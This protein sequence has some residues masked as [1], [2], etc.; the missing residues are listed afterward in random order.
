MSDCPSEGRE[1]VLPDVFHPVASPAAPGRSLVS[2]PVQGAPLDEANVALPASRANALR[3]A[4]IHPPRVPA[5]VREAEGPSSSGNGPVRKDL[6]PVSRVSVKTAPAGVGE[7]E[8]PPCEPSGNGPIRKDPKPVSRVSVKTASAGV[9]GAEDPPCEPSGKGPVRKDPKLASRVNVKTAA[10][11]HL[12]CVPAGVGE[13]KDPPRA[14]GGNRPT[15]NDPKPASKPGASQSSGTAGAGDAAGSGAQPKKRPLPPS[16]A[17]AAGRKKA[18][19][20]W[21]EDGIQEVFVRFCD[22]EGLRSEDPCSRLLFFSVVWGLVQGDSAKLDAIN[23]SSLVLEVAFQDLCAQLGEVTYDVYPSKPP[24][25]VHYSLV[26][27]KLTALALQSLEGTESKETGVHYMFDACRLYFRCT[28][29][30]E[31]WASVGKR[32]RT[33][34]TAYRT[35]TRGGAWARERCWL[36]WALTVVEQYCL[37]RRIR[38]HGD[39]LPALGAPQQVAERRMMSDLVSSHL[40]LRVVVATEQSLG[41]APSPFHLQQP[42]SVSH[43]DVSVWLRGITSACITAPL[44][45]VFHF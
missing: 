13:A 41:V 24:L 8:D 25:P 17:R 30:Y 34:A 20:D 23:D 31:G 2:P 18:R 22:G 15:R 19:V 1:S 28:I 4:A 45:S 33:F 9:G 5:G 3:A 16:G 11:S 44:P 43:G 38:A 39:L 14:P 21:P 35:A 37:V 29:S 7:A 27:D 32:V 10:A 12:P 36:L 6:K 26:A 40:F 42:F